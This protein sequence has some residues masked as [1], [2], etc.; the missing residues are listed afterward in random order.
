MTY[1]SC[2]VVNHSL[3]RALIEEEDPEEGCWMR[4]DF[5][6]IVWVVVVLQLRKISTGHEVE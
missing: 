6:K 4:C 1:Y 3:Q 5:E 2:T